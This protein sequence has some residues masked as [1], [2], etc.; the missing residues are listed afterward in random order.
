MPNFGEQ[1]GGLS[2][3]TPEQEAERLKLLQQPSEVTVSPMAAKP[4][5]ESAEEVD[6]TVEEP[7]EVAVSVEPE[8]EKHDAHVDEFEVHKKKVA[9][10]EALALLKNSP[11]YRAEMDLVE[12]VRRDFFQY[13]DVQRFIQESV[14]DG[15]TASNIALSLVEGPRYSKP[16]TLEPGWDKA[17]KAA[18]EALDKGLAR[19]DQKY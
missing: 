4:I 6:A 16:Y 7:K 1:P 15:A 17:A 9:D 8:G 5:A 19:I 18:S 11:R 14:S 12:T 3:E 13:P 10:A 2:L